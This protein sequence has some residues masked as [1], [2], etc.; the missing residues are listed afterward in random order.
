MRRAMIHARIARLG[1]D[2]EQLVDPRHQLRRHPIL[3][4]Q[5]DRVEYLSPRMRPACRMHHPDP[6]H[7]TVSGITIGLQNTFILSE[8]LHRAVAAPPHSEVEHCLPVCHTAT[9]KPDGSSRARPTS[10][11]EPAFHPPVCSFRQL[12]RAPSP[13][14]SASASRRP[15]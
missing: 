1:I 2:R 14:P 10:A 3:R 6:T 4:I 5:F 11:P 13:P 8:E 9:E 7:T 15:A 12:T